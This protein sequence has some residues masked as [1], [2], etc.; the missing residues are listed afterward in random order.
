M[1]WRCGVKS[2]TWPRQSSVAIEAC[3]VLVLLVIGSLC[4]NCSHEDCGLPTAD[5]KCP[6][7]VVLS[8]RSTLYI[9]NPFG[10]LPRLGLEFWGGW[11]ADRILLPR[12]EPQPDE[13]PE[14]CISGGAGTR[15]GCAGPSGGLSAGSL[16]SE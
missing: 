4:P 5:W 1:S 10:R 16:V 12:G 2:P 7:T 15:E 13:G 9:A 8:Q 3:N 11:G 14:I 6:A